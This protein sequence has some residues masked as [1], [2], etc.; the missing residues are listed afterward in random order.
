M[1]IAKA[2]ANQVVQMVEMLLFYLNALNVPLTHGGSILLILNDEVAAVIGS[3]EERPF[4]ARFQK[5]VLKRLL[6]HH[7]TVPLQ[8]LIDRS[9]RLCV[10]SAHA[11]LQ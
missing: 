8:V 1:L 11:I 9:P 10:R 4:A 6:P 5:S 7:A 2:V 3:D